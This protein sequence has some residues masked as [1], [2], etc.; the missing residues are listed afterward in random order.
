[1]PDGAID[2]VVE[3]AGKLPS[4]QSE[5][6]IGVVSGQANRIPKEATAYSQRDAKL[7]IN[8][9]SRWDKAEEDKKCISWARDFF[10]A[11]A[12]FATGGVYVNFLT[13][14]EAGRVSAAYG[15]NYD[16]LVQLKRKYDP[17]NLFRLNQNIK[18]A[19]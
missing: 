12:P 9:H 1:M 18:P 11:T 17:G 10:N 15:S 16:R 14:D 5:V 6:F 7:V 4:P 2:R 19:A 3:Y 8:V 13:Q